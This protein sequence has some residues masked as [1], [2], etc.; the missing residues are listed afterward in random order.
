[1]GKMLQ[2]EILKILFYLNLVKEMDKTSLIKM[3][4]VM[5]MINTKEIKI[6]NLFKKI[7]LK[8]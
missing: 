2:L 7:T 6:K 5:K 4:I 3:M 8:M 1:M